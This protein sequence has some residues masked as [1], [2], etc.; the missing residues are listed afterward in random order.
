MDPARRR[1]AAAVAR[2]RALAAGLLKPQVVAGCQGATTLLPGLVPIG[3]GFVPFPVR[4]PIFSVTV[5][6]GT[7]PG[8]CTFYSALTAAG[9]MNL[10]TPLTTAPVTVTP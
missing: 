9:T 1:R 3:R 8:A 7:P 6:P 5:A 4:G 2:P 10:V